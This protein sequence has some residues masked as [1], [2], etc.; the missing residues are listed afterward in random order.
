MCCS[1]CGGRVFVVIVVS[2]ASVF[3]GLATPGDDEP[4]IAQ[5]R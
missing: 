1:Q 3:C 5:G 2:A 4:R